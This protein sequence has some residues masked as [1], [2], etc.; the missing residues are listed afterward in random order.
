ME[1][2]EIL[3]LSFNQDRTLLTV[4]TRNGFKIFRVN[5]FE[6]IHQEGRL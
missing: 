1:I 2:E 6:Q 4:G 3:H 5:P